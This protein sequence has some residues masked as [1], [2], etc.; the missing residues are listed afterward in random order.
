MVDKKYIS[1]QNIYG[2]TR[3]SILSNPCN[4]EI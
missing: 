2:N 3:G 4:L 1:S